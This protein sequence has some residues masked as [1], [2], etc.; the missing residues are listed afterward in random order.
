MPE[1]TQN[2]MPDPHEE[3]VVE[4]KPVKEARKVPPILEQLDSKRT[5]GIQRLRK[6][7]TREQLGKKLDREDMSQA[8]HGI[9]T[10]LSA[11]YGMIAVLLKDTVAALSMVRAIE[12][13]MYQLAIQLGTV[14][15]VLENKGMITEDEIKKTWEEEVKPKY[16]AAQKAAQEASTE[17]VD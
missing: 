12:N 3:P 1:E 2:L 5:E 10:I 6:V 4:D 15:K 14:A 7:L 8:L 11:E 9:D 13:S 17:P 16:E